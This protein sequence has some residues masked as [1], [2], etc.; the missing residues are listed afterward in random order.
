M[1]RSCVRRNDPRAGV[2][3]GRVEARLFEDL[4]QTIYGSR[5]HLTLAAKAFLDEHV[6]S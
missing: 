2:P 1:S 6:S 5:S 3:V 4:G